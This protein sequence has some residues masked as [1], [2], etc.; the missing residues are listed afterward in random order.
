MLFNFFPL[1]RNVNNLPRDVIM[2]EVKYFLITKQ[3]KTNDS[4]DF[5]GGPRL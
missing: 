3:G 2:S 5:N 1:R 4:L